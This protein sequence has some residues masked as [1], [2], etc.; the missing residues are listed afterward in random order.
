METALS[1]LKIDLGITHNL[2]DEYFNKLLDGCKS[3]IEDRG[4]TL[5]LNISEDLMLLTDYSAWRYRNRTDDKP[6]PKNVEWRL[7][8]LKTKVRAIYGD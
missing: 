7:M 1:L 8:T 5:D 3:E 6:I 4:I 2:R